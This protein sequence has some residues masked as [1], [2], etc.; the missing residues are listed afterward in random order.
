MKDL[1][2]SLQDSKIPGMKLIS[3]ILRIFF[4]IGDK[5]S[6]PESTPEALEKKARY[7]LMT[8]MRDGKNGYQM[9]EI[10]DEK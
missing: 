6:G 5:K 2:K 1:I 7:E 8:K 9:S 10:Y 4:G 3:E